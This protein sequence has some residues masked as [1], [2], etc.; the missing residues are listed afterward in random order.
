[1]AS[2]YRKKMDSGELSRYRRE[3]LMEM[4]TVGDVLKM[5]KMLNGY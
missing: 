2:P 4:Q 3:K 5:E 1:M